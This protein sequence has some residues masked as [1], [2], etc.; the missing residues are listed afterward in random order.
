MKIT[1]RTLGILI[2]MLN[3]AQ[4]DSDVTVEIFDGQDIECFLAEFKICGKDHDCLDDRHP[5]LLV[6]MVESPLDG[7]KDLAIKEMGQ[8]QQEI[9]EEDSNT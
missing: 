8:I 2:G 5:V 3:D 1:Y 4:L 6:N 9:E 7:D